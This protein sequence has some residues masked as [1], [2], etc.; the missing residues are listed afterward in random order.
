MSFIAGQNRRDAVLLRRFGKEHLYT[1]IG[2][3][4]ITVTGMFEKPTRQSQAGQ[5]AVSATF[6]MISVLRSEVPNL[7]QGDH[8]KI[9]G[10]KYRAKGPA[11]DEGEVVAV[12]LEKLR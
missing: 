10:E 1:A 8:F 2:E 5:R 12:D 7:R 4:T 9:A 3:G 11:P 6:P